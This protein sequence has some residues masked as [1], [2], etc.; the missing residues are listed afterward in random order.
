M[1]PKPVD[2]IW[3]I[4]RQCPWDCAICCVDAVPLRTFE[5]HAHPPELSYGEKLAVL[6]NLSGFAPKIDISGG[7]PLAL[8]EA[9][10]LIEECARRFGPA[11]VTITATG[12]TLGH[13]SQDFAARHIGELNFTYDM[14]EAPD[15]ET[16]PRRYASANLSAARA[17]VQT[18]LKLRAECPLTTKNVAPH[19]LERVYLDLHG[20]GVQ[21]LLVTRMFPVGRGRIHASLMPSPG[22]YRTAVA[23]LRQ[24]EAQHGRPKIK[25]QCALRYFDTSRQAA[26]PCDLLH[27]SLGL[28]P[29]GTLLASPWAYGLHGQ[30][31][32]ESWVLGNLAQTPLSSILASERARYY[33]AHLDDNFGHCKIFA[34]LGS[35]R[36][37][38]LERIFDA[39]DPL[40]AV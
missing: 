38:S 37:T 40:L 20:A 3:N 28:M 36:E 14:P 23:R 4:T 18:G 32:D 26:N 5:T 8:P 31:L 29:D 27:L 22:Q 34:W 39:T 13:L 11:N 7:D 30:P 19:Q 17:F 2:L 9:L 21:T 15:A 25:L 12:A 16:R 35:K 6:D 1:K 10:S 24:L 33:Q